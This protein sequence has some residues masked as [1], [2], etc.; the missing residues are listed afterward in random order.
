MTKKDYQKENEELRNDLDDIIHRVY[1]T[2][3][4]VKITESD[5]GGHFDLDDSYS[6]FFYSVLRDIPSLTKKYGFYPFNQE[7]VRV[8]DDWSPVSWGS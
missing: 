1:Q 8:G 2:N 6:G 3:I 7:E 4:D 5:R